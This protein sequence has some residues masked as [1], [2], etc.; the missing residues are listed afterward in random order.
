MRNLPVF[1]LSTA[2]IL[3]A[4]AATTIPVEPAKAAFSFNINFGFNTFRDRLSVQGR[5]LRSPIWGDVWQPRRRLVG[6]DFQPYT[7]G[8][9]QYT[10]EYG[11]YW[12]SEDPF[13]DV[14]YHYGRWVYDPDQH[15][16]WI[17]GYTWGP[18]WVVWREGGGYS[19]WMPMPPDEAFVSGRGLSLGMNFGAWNVNLYG[20]N[21]WYGNRVDPGRFWVFVDNRNLAD[22]DY[23]RFVAPPERA[24]V[25]L[26]NTRNVTNFTVVN[27]RVV[28]RSIDVN[29]VERAS[30]RR[31]QPV[32]ARTVMKPNA[33]VTTVDES[34]HVRERE[35]AAHPIRSDAFT[36]GAGGPG[37]AMGGPGGATGGRGG[38][39][40][41]PGGAMG[42][43]GGATNGTKPTGGNAAGGAM[44]GGKTGANGAPTG[45]N[46][47]GGSMS[48]PAA[49][50]PNGT[51]PATGNE[52]GKGGS[53]NPSGPATAP[54][55]S[56]ATNGA[57]ETG[58]TT[59]EKP[60]HHRNET[61]GGSMGGPGGSPSSQ[62]PGATSPSNNTAPGGAT[63]G[64]RN[65]SPSDNGMSGPSD[66]GAPPSGPRHR[67]PNPNGGGMSGPGGP[68]GPAQSGPAP[69]GPSPNGAPPSANGAT[70]GQQPD[71]GTPPKK[72][73][74][75]NQQP[76]TTPD[77]SAPPQE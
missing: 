59:T 39:M 33:I 41:G 56:G 52:A 17:P 34:N 15:W 22:R 36:G 74:R 40:G 76:G 73:N 19:G 62:Q 2:A 45:G 53:R 43:P 4:G 44:T 64:P 1:A 69:N 55:G 49:T 75:H 28:N 61:P 35:R 13:D 51:P 46:A 9:W 12:V 71:N 5:W 14:V 72:K 47:A 66:N 26:T 54:S 30:G 10:S 63:G 70:N 37:G 23:R 32:A 31:I 58:G 77:S 60:K 18:G 16:L 38:T 8:Y 11:W 7:N 65:L 20:Y 29:V 24:R 57:A 25:L 3:L 21:R 67:A 42:G 48:G 50:T 27:N 6:P 68:N